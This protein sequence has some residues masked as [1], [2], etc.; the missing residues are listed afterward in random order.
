MVTSGKAWRQA[1]EQGVEL[2]F[3]SGNTAAIRPIEV[4]FF[5]RV[6]HI[7]DGLAGTV[8]K[9]INGETVKI[10]DIPASEELEKSK[11]WL[12]FLNHLA[13]FAFVNP[14]VVENPQADDEIAVDDLSYTDKVF[15]YQFF[16]RPAQIL[17]SFRHAQTQSVASVGASGSNGAASQP[18]ATDQPV[19]HAGDGDARSMDS[20][21]V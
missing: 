12:T 6:G 8:S 2:T 5:V 7:P 20:H 10:G 18:V 16:C 11:E 14:K 17:R 21:P 15:L 3:P 9:L 13:T 1:R 4:D 19:G